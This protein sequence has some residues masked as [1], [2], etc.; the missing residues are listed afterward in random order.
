M[1]TR[2]RVLVT[3]ATAAGSTEGIAERIAGTLRAAGAEVVCRPAGPDADLQ[4]FDAFVVGSAVHNMAWLQPA[5]DLVARAHEI[6]RPV[7]C[8]SVGGI[9]PRGRLTRAMTDRELRRIAQAFPGSFVPRD[10]RMFGGIIDMQHT[11][12]WG[13]LFFRATGGRP[14]DHRDWAAVEAWAAEIAAGLTGRDPAVEP[15]GTRRRESGTA[16]GSGT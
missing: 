12:L 4:P 6:G 15:M 5:V 2:R 14:G 13:R 16:A 1:D 10:H 11:P 8:F 7:W 9:Q 3:Y